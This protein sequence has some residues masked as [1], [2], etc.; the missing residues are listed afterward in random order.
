MKY[1]QLIDNIIFNSF[2]LDDLK[3]IY[4][5]SMVLI[6]D[7]YKILLPPLKEIDCKLYKKIF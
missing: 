2:D 4:I 1:S 5:L 6:Q 3:G 7:D